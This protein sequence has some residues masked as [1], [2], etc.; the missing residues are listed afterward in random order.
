MFKAI[1]KLASPSWIQASL[2]VLLISIFMASWFIANRE[3]EN[4]VSQETKTEELEKGDTLP[5]LTRIDPIEVTIII[6]MS[7]KIESNIYSFGIVILQ[8]KP[9]GRHFLSLPKVPFL[10]YIYL[11]IP[12]TYH[13]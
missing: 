7:I 11:I 10:S 5:K 6:T 2:L 9:V 13:S 1:F 4:P 3:N 12:E 8:R